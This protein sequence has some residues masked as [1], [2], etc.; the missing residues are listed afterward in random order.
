MDSGIVSAKTTSDGGANENALGNCSRHAEICRCKHLCEL[1][2]HL[3]AFL[4]VYHQFLQIPFGIVLFFI[5][6]FVFRRRRRPLVEY[7]STAICD[8]LECVQRET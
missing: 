1:N 4:G 8:T 2:V 3:S 5:L 6:A 7:L